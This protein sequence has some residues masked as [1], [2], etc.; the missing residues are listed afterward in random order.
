MIIILIFYILFTIFGCKLTNNPFFIDAI[1]P[2]VLSALA[3]YAFK[4]SENYHGRFRN[5]RENTKLMVI[6][7]IIYI[8]VFSISGLVVG[9]A[10]SIYSHNF[11]MVLKNIYQITFIAILIEYLRSYLIN[12]NIKSKLNI[13]AITTLCILLEVNFSVL[14]AKFADGKETFEYVSSIILPIIFS[15]IMYSFASLKGG[16]KMTIPYRIITSIFLLLTPVVPAFDWFLTGIFGIIYPAI[17]IMIVQKYSKKA[18]AIRRENKKTSAFVYSICIILMITFTL[19]VYGF[20]KYKPI[21]V[22]SNSMSP[23]FNKGDVALYYVPTDEEKIKLENN[24]IIVYTKDNQYVVHRIVR[25]FKKAGEIFYITRGD[26]NN[27]DD[28]SPVAT[29]DIVGVYTTSIKY[30]GYP[31]VWLNQLFNQQKAVVE[32]K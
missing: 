31:S 22:L 11:F 32:T 30:V 24:T 16:Y 27:S 26:A 29:S 21:V 6:M 28:Y 25:N 15:N 2:V 5:V 20:F 1:K 17:I 19:A 9:F 4:K 23:S 10:Y 7:A 13:V 12:Q 14:F 18:T 8:L 3:F